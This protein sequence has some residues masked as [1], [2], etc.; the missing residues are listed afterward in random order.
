MSKNWK[1]STGKDVEN[2][3]L[4]KEIR[5][6]IEERERLEIGTVFTWIKGHAADPGNEAADRLA[7]AGAHLA[8]ARNGR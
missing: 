5:K 3:D 7:V 4:I 6:L 8:R 1:T 2:Q